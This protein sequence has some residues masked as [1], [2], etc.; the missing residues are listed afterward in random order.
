MVIPDSYDK[1]FFRPNWLPL[2]SGVWRLL[3]GVD[4][5][6]SLASGG[7]ATSAPMSARRSVSLSRLSFVLLLSLTYML[8]QLGERAYMTNDISDEKMSKKV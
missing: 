6:P 8:K 1:H 2:E 3:P 5:S 7:A 4:R